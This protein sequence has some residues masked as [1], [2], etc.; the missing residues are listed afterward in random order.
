LNSFF[1][2]HKNILII[3][4][5]RWEHLFVSKHHYAIELAKNNNK[6]FFLNPPSNRYTCKETEYSNVWQIEYTPFLKG[7]RFF[8][9]G[10]QRY[11]MRAKFNQI[12][13]IAKAD[14]QI[15]WSFDNSVF[16]DLSALPKNIFTISHI[17]DHSQNFQFS[18][19][20]FTAKLCLGVSQNIVDRQKQYNK[21]SFLIPHGLSPNL[22]QSNKVILPGKNT[23]KAVYAGNLD[24]IYL[25]CI[26]LFKLTDQFTNVDFVFLGSGGKAWPQKLNTFFL[27]LI[28][29]RNLP[30]YLHQADVLL[31]LYDVDKFPNQLTNA[32]KVLEYLESGKV[33]VSCFVPDYADKPNLIEMALTKQMIPTLFTKIISNLDLYN[34]MDNASKRKNFALQNTTAHRTAEIEERICELENINL[35]SHQ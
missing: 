26:S 32:H 1:L 6:V 24:S 15:V 33:I 31:L 2:R 16:F 10:L 22:T 25:D 7:L 27:G 11:L 30:D 13:K 8:P 19:T 3:S 12:Q 28:D 29:R 18:K 17:V 34:S 9:S 20:A 5:E 14:F 35:Q 21:N 4:P 23:I